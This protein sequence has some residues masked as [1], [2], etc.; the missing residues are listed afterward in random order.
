MKNQGTSFDKQ[1][2]GFSM[3]S[4]TH[5]CSLCGWVNILSS[6]QILLH[7]VHIKHLALALLLAGVLLSVPTEPAGCVNHCLSCLQC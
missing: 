6:P 3:E 5:T 2:V 7:T 4:H 1:D